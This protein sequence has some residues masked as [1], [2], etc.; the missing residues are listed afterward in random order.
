MTL[1]TLKNE[2]LLIDQ[3]INEP[4][5]EHL[6][7]LY[8]HFSRYYQAIQSLDISNKDIVIDASCG[9]GYGSYILSTKAKKVIGLD[10]N[11][12]YLK[13]AKKFFSS[14]KIEFFSYDDFKLL[15]HNQ[16]HP[17]VRKIVSIETFEHIPPTKVTVFINTLLSYLEKGGSLFLTVPIGNN[18]P[19]S[20]NKYH[21]N[22]PSVEKIY[23]MFRHH[24]IHL[25]FDISSFINSFGYETSY[26]YLLL[27]Q[28]GVEL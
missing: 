18:T 25:N 26:C 23:K 6:M 14:P 19:S 8:N 12:D 3:I 1:Y 5:K 21:L 22:E 11:L 28:M 15:L 24:F 2:T 17:K 10:T 7:L 16:K 9:Y 4:L 13:N 20:Y 27:R